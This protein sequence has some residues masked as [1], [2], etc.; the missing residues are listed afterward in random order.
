LIYKP[1]PLDDVCL[2]ETSRRQGKEDLLR[3]RRWNEDL[4]RAQRWDLREK[5]GQTPTTPQAADHIPG[6]D[7]ISDNESD[8]SSVC[9]QNSEP[10]GEYVDDDYDDDDFVCI[11]HQPPAPNI[12][13]EGAGPNIIPEGDDSVQAPEGVPVPPAPNIR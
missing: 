12:G 6:R 3:Q 4:M 11:R 10:E 1:P 9:S 2:D 5:V 7:A 13:N 8:A